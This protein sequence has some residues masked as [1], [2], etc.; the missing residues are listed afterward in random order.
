MTGSI[1]LHPKFGLNP[2]IPTCFWCGKDKNELI[3]L[4]AAFKEEAPR[5]MYLDYEPCD[6]CKDQ[7]KLGVTLI[8]ANDWG[9]IP[10]ERK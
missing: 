10:I 9:S 8:E 4:G 1:R 7:M 3:L 2:T 6:T 5:H